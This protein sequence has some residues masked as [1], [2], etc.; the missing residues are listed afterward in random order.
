MS[1]R[2]RNMHEERKMLVTRGC[3]HL[4]LSS[5]CLTAGDES[6]LFTLILKLLFHLIHCLPSLQPPNHQKEYNQLFMNICSSALVYS[7][8]YTRVAV[9]RKMRFYI[10]EI[11][12]AKN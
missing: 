9:Q 5:L 6:E 11:L 12:K 8:L 1:E 10:D 2:C 7:L 3:T 4:H